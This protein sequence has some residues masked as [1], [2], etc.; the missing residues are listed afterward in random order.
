MTNDI[1]KAMERH[2]REFAT[3][4]EW[5]QIKQYDAISD[6]IAKLKELRD[7]FALKYIRIQ[8]RCSQR[9]RYAMKRG[10]NG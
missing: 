10:H 2:W 7:T 1:E 3:K 6:Q 9:K 5:E 4:E 8:Q